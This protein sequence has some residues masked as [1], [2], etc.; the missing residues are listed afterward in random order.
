LLLVLP[1]AALAALAILAGASSAAL[2]LGS[3]V[4]DLLDEVVESESS[5]PDAAGR[6]RV[7]GGIFGDA[8]E[9]KVDLIRRSIKVEPDT[10]TMIQELLNYL[11][12]LTASSNRQCKW[13]FEALLISLFQGQQ[14][15]LTRLRRVDGGKST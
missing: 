14:V 12:N 3:L 5:A 8:D 6:F 13:A 1:L 15:R 11:T 4:L 10:I 2:L 9:I 7:R